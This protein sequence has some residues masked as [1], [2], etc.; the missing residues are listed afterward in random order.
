M[1]QYTRELSRFRDLLYMLVWRDISIKY[2]QSVM[3]L[4]WAVLMPLLIVCAGALVRYAFSEV[5]HQPLAGTDIAAVSVKAIPWAFFV[6]SVRFSTL[7]LISNT[8]L[9]TKIY[10]P[11]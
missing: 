11:R 3:G 2:K 8:N 7:S 4:L 6:A 10:F 5:S 1:F 9:V